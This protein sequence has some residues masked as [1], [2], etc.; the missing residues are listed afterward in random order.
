MKKLLI[1]FLTFILFA[2]NKTEKKQFSYWK[3]NGQEYSSNNV[4]SSIGKAVANIDCLDKNSFDVT[5]QLPFLPTDRNLRITN[6]INNQSSDLVKLNF[7]LDTISYH[8][9]INENKKLIASQVNNKAH[10]TME[11]TWFVNYNNPAD[12]ILIEAT[13]NEP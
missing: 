4:T 12:S 2:C 6:Q 11:A 3:I 10:Y 8:I 13:I 1:V 7:Y 9:S 5:F